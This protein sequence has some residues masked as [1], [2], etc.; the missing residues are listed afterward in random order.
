MYR[1]LF[2]ALEA[3]TRFCINFHLA[4]K[5]APLGRTESYTRLWCSD[6]AAV[7]HMWKASWYCVCLRTMELRKLQGGKNSQRHSKV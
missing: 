1:H 6:A 3:V 4:H 5:D 7:V 2:S